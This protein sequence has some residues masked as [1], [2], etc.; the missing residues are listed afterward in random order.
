MAFQT[1][2]GEETIHFDFVQPRTT[3]TFAIRESYSIDEKNNVGIFTL[4]TC[5]YDEYYRKMLGA[6]FEKVFS[7]GVENVVVDLRGNQGGNSRVANEF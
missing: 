4:P 7:S 3:N 6:F 2:N 1:E 5:Q